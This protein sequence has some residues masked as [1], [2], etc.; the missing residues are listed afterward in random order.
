MRQRMAKSMISVVLAGI[1]LYGA[2]ASAQDDIGRE[3]YRDSCAACHG[4]EGKGDGPM[5]DWL[6]K[7]APDLTRLAATNG[8][9]F[10]FDRVFQIVDGRNPVGGHGS[11]DMPVWGSRFAKE[12][13]GNLGLFVSEMIVRGRILSVV[14]HIQSLQQAP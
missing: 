6:R 5:V 12:D 14:Y 10:P 4:L 3:E 9:V 1:L 8:D 13:M 11:R 7:P 2:G